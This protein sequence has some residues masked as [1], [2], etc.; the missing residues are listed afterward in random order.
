LA[1]LYTVGLA[2]SFTLGFGYQDWTILL[3]RPKVQDSLGLLNVWWEPPTSSVEAMLQGGISTDIVAWG[4]IIFAIS[5]LYISFFFFT[6]SISLIFRRSWLDIE[7][8]PFPL[9]LTNYEP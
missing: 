8:V 1:Y 6:S 2:T 4:P 7:K 9:A 3:S 5:L